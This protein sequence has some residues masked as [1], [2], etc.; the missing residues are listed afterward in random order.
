MKN[1]NY[2]VYTA[3]FG[4]YDDLI[5]PAPSN[6]C[7]YI[8]FTDATHL[9]SNNWKIQ[10]VSG[11]LS[12]KMMNRLY[13]VKPH[14]YLKNY[15]ASIYLDTNIKILK[16]PISLF[17]KYLDSSKFLTIKHAE[18]GCIYSEALNCMA[19]KKAD[20]KVTMDQMF[21]YAKEGY[22]ANNNLTE[23][24]ILIRSHNDQHVTRLMEMWWNELNTWTQRDQLSL[25]YV[26]WKLKFKIDC[27]YENPRFKNDY[28]K[29]YPHNKT[30]KRFFYRLIRKLKFYGRWIL[31]YPNF[32][33]KIGLLGNPY[34]NKP[35]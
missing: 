26:A 28:F 16:D 1:K 20:Y 5:E 18:R 25:C 3:L 34:F 9:Q 2:V 7:D 15:K 17:Q 32:T 22:P 33:F 23:N 14:E 6:D 12:A 27:I 24:R 35:S 19:S 21:S 13:K 30:E 8:C 29:W 31:F 4:N 11:N 10:I